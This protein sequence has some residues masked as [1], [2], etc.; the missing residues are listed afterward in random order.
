MKRNRIKI[1]CVAMALFATVP[2][3]A[4]EPESDFTAEVGGDLVSSYIWRGQACGG[5][6]LQPSV[7]IGWKGFSF[8]AWGSV[9]FESFDTKE[10]DLTLG[11]GIGGFSVSV[12]DYYFAV[13][14]VPDSYFHYE[15]DATPHV[16]E[17]QIGYDFGFL[18]LNWFTNFAGADG[19]KN[20][21]GDMAYSSYFTI[22]APFEFGSLSWEAE[23]GFV[24]WKTSLYATEGFALTNISIKALKPIPISET[25]NL[26]LFTQAIWNPTSEGGFLV[27][28]LSF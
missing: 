2:L 11:Y 26:G 10:F 15:K 14:G 24:P 27:M 23:L 18:S 7:E 21:N 16:F 22:G 5:V 13:P 9:G 3:F 4:D 8:G 19:V 1:V 17:G 25:Y 6:S 20:A 12:T 28:G